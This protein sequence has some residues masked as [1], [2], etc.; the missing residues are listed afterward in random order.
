[1]NGLPLNN[2]VTR[3][4]LLLA[5]LTGVSWWLGAGQGMDAAQSAQLTTI[6]LLLLAFFKV[7]LVIMYFM[8]IR[9]A[10]LLLRFIFEAWVV[11][12]CAAVLAIY[13]LESTAY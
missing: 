2:A 11:V 7:R 4:W 8:E 12:V 13:L 5:G 1:M 10:P 6:G 9:T 3:V